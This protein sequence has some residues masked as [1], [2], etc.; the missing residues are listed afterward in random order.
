MFQ[1]E[2]GRRSP[3]VRWKLTTNTWWLWIQHQNTS[4]QRQDKAKLSPSGCVM[5]TLHCD[6][7]EVKSWC[8]SPPLTVHTLAGLI[9]TN[10]FSPGWGSDG[11]FVENLW[12]DYWMIGGVDCGQHEWTVRWA[13]MW[14]WCWSLLG[15]PFTWQRRT[16]APETANIR[17]ESFE[18]ATFFTAVLTGTTERGDDTNAGTSR[19][20]SP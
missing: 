13:V 20:I 3:Q 2:R 19:C 7:T 14:F 4:L 12:L 11:E 16:G 9:H 15:L 1:L 6:L 8:F 5:Q 18:T 17:V 10:S